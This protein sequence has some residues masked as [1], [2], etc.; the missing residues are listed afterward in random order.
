MAYKY[1]YE[2]HKIT[3]GLIMKIIKTDAQHAS[4]EFTAY[5]NQQLAAKKTVC[6]FIPGGSN[7]THVVSILQNVHNRSLLSI[8]LT[9]ERYGPYGHRDSNWFQLKELGASL[10][11]IH[12]FAVIRPGSSLEE[13]TQYYDTFARSLIHDSDISICMLGMGQDGHIAGILPQS[14]AAK[15]VLNYVHNYS[16]PPFERITLTFKAISACTTVFCFA[17]GAGKDKILTDFESNKALPVVLP[18]QFL[19]ELP[20]AYLYN[21]LIG[22][23][24]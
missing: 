9:D 11:D 21:E 5:L 1:Y 15:D 16:A 18:V 8:S 10:R 6:W 20:H 2:T 17:Y 3:A 4:E 22:E 7:L 19:K 12:T 13:T 24:L 14:E 23:S